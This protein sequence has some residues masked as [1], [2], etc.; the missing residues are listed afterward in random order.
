MIK[1]GVG[2]IVAASVVFL[3]LAGCTGIG[4]PEADQAPAPA[5][6]RGSAGQDLV[7]AEAVIVPYREAVLSLRAGGHVLEVLVGEGD[8]VVAGQALVRTDV[9]DLEQAVRQ[10]EAALKSVEAALAKARAGTRAEEITAAEAGVASAEWDVKAAEEGVE[11]AQG[12]LNTVKAKVTTAQ[13]G[14]QVARGNV[15]AAQARVT[16]VQALLNKLLAGATAREIRIAEKQLELA[17]NELY[18]I[19]R[20]R[21]VSGTIPEEQVTAAET[22]V[23]IAQLQLDNTKAGTRAEDISI[24]RA[25]V[26]QA[27]ADVQVAQGQLLQAQSAVEQAKS[28][29]TI[30]D[31]QLAA[32]KAQV[33]TVRATARQ[34]EAQLARLKAGS[35]TEDVTV[36][37]SEVGRAQAVL[38][39]ARSTLADATLKAPFDGTV[40]IVLLNAGEQVLPQRPVLTIGDFTRWRAETEDLSEADV[41]LVRVGQ[42]A[43]VTVDALEGKKLTGTVAE[44]APIASDSRG[45]KVYTVKVDLDAAADSGLRWGMSAFVETT[46]R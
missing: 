35:R 13:S 18:A 6:A 42:Q 15:S 1:H 30:A 39:E 16:E 29:V 7:S 9:R 27:N 38:A 41:S 24:A 11:V 28:L 23:T 46:V 20:Q 4:A 25:E 31:G 17:K 12:D 36:A 21:E 26:A 2:C 14:L 10:A 19:Q 5:V 8:E 32:A 3:A 34:A 45:D 22:M 44:I 33:E 43:A 40:G 37:E